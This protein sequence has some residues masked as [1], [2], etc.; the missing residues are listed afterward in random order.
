MS[1]IAELRSAVAGVQTAVAEIKGMVLA[2][3]TAQ[4][5]QITELTRR[6]NEHDERLL[7]MTQKQAADTAA[8][9]ATA[10]EKA[11]QLARASTPKPWAAYMVA[12][13]T[14]VL[15]LITWWAWQHP[16]VAPR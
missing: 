7:A 10:A 8:S 1:E 2:T 6:V 15:A 5:Q 3:L 13:G 14:L 9:I 16:L 11:T 12:V 4:A